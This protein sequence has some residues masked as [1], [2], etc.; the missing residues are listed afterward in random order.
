V[1]LAPK[2]ALLLERLGN[3]LIRQLATHVLEISYKA[4][5]AKIEACPTPEEGGKTPND[6]PI[7]WTA[8]PLLTSGAISG[9]ARPTR[10]VETRN[11]VSNNL[12]L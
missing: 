7:W 4:Y 5:E 6:D 9:T 12:I 2:P 3:Y 10:A 11:R 1:S 8:Q